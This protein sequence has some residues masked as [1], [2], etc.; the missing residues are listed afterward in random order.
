VLDAFLDWVLRLPPGPTYLVLALLAAVENVFPPVPAD[1]AVALGAFL[2]GRGEVGA[3]PLGALC[4]AA[5]QASAMGLYFFARK[6]GPAF[7]AHGLGRRLLPP[8]AMNALKQ[9]SERYGVFAIFVSRFLPGLRAAVLP[10]AGAVGVSPVRALVPAGIAS[11]I[12]YAFLVGAAMSLGRNLE[13]VRRFVEDA[14][15]VL[16]LVALVVTALFALWL[17]QRTR[18]RRRAKR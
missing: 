8:K 9:A 6:R 18:K 10:F 1:M 3:W 7:F 16:S 4:W 13:S 2:A 15:R 14:N 5:N 12:W 11:A 17:W